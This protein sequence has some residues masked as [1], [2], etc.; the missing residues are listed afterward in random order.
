MG[1]KSCTPSMIQG[2]NQSLKIQI[3]IHLLGIVQFKHSLILCSNIEL[4]PLWQIAYCKKK[5]PLKQR[6]Q[7]VMKSLLEQ[8]TLSDAH[9]T[10]DQSHFCC[11]DSRI[12]LQDYKDQS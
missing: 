1:T 12:N 7:I 9:F 2:K 5:R 6:I 3:Q 8:F 11:Q 4:F 10:P